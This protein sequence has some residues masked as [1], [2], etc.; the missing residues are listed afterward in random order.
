MKISP[1]TIIVGVFAVLFGL[2][3]A[4]AVRQQLTKK[5]VE[6]VASPPAAPRPVF[7]PVAAVDLEPGRPLTLS[8]VAIVQVAPDQLAA[9]GFN[10][11]YMRD[12]Q[13]IIGRILRGPVV[14]GKTFFPEL[15]YPQGQGP[16]VAERLKPGYRAVTATIE[17]DAAVAG[18]APPGSLVDVIF[19]TQA[20][21]NGAHPQTTVTLLEGVEVLAIGKVATPGAQVNTGRSDRELTVTLAVSGKQANALRV[22]EGHGQLSLAL[23][24]P[25]DLATATEGEAQTLGGLLG[26]PQ[27]K[28]YTTEVYRGSTRNT[29]TFVD[30]TP[31]SFQ[32]NQFPVRADVEHPT[33]LPEPQP[34]ADVLDDAGKAASAAPADTND[35]RL[36]TVSQ[37][38]PLPP[39]DA[40]RPRLGLSGLPLLS[41]E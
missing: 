19:R 6:E 26:L 12:S 30:P 11:P 5:P 25:R 27:P 1:G 10:G 41:G 36:A 20:E 3:G 9:R 15:F 22:V 17:N 33:S 21:E 29:V 18:L 7:V 35:V 39:A 13:Q 38:R 37:S 34:P 31:A 28:S 8:D 23:R 40:S 24:N 16:S 32:L 2:V 4:Y 14:K